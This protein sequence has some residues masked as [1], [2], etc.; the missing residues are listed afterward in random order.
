MAKFPKPLAASNFSEAIAY[1]AKTHTH[2]LKSAR[3][4]FVNRWV[5]TILFVLC[6]LVLIVGV[7]WSISSPEEQAVLYAKIPIVFDMWE[8]IYQAASSFSSKWYI[9][10]GILVAAAYSIPW[11]VCA[12]IAC[13][14]AAVI[15]TGPLP[16][17][18]E[19]D[20]AIH[21]QALYTMTKD[22]A[23]FE[24]ALGNVRGRESTAHFRRGFRV[25]FA[26][27]VT[28]I[29]GVALF[30]IAPTLGR[31]MTTSVIIGLLFFGLLVYFA[32]GPLLL[33]FHSL[34][35]M[36]GRPGKTLSSVATDLHAFW[37]SVDSKAKEELEA[38]LKKEREREALREAKAARVRET[39]ERALQLERNGSDALAKEKFFEAAQM[40]DSISMYNYARHC[41]IDGNRSQAIY[42]LQRCVD[43]G[44]ADSQVEELLQALKDGVSIN[45]V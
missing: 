10:W 29:F 38:E 36:M 41:Y 22:Y 15:K 40:G 26:V 17:S 23:E 27:C 12:V 43:T 25:F 33:L 1:V 21:A 35:F 6:S 37:M 19:G 2:N 24:R 4:F 45:I 18:R 8:K 31:G 11:C 13:V 30:W 9:T 39:R 32:Y 42:W 28:A 5:G 44:E 16:D 7:A 14:I 3:M 20:I 34:L